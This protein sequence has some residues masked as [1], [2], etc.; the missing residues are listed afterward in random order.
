MLKSFEL[1]FQAAERHFCLVIPGLKLSFGVKL[2]LEV[3]IQPLS[4]DVKSR[5]LL[6]GRGVS[7]AAVA[8]RQ[9]PSCWQ[10]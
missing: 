7:R 2:C 4:I 9:V 8:A 6:L 3:N 10:H 1:E 5:P